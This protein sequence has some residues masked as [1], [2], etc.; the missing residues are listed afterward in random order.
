[1]FDEQFVLSLELKRESGDDARSHTNNTTKCV[2]ERVREGGITLQV[3]LAT[4]DASKVREFNLLAFRLSS[5]FVSSF[6]GKWWHFIFRLCASFSGKWYVLQDQVLGQ[7]EIANPDLTKMG[8]TVCTDIKCN[9][10]DRSKMEP[11]DLLDT[12]LILIRA[13]YTDAAAKVGGIFSSHL[14]VNRSLKNIM[15]LAPAPNPMV[16]CGAGGRA[17]ALLGVLVA[18]RNQQAGSGLQLERAKSPHAFAAEASGQVKNAFM[19]L[20]DPPSSASPNAVEFHVS[21][22]EWAS[23]FEA[24]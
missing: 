19:A 14:L 21:S 7:I 4:G 22:G 8:C 2:W 3:S 18:E 5:V 6:S 9:A 13:F 11:C 16:W 15:L 20:R 23:A 10:P 24:G 1:L 12:N 17:A